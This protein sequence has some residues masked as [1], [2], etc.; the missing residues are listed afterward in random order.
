M[1]T[2][3]EIFHTKL[4]NTFGIKNESEGYD[5]ITFE[6]YKFTENF[7]NAYIKE[8]PVDCYEI[9]ELTDV[10]DIHPSLKFYDSKAS[11]EDE[12]SERIE[13]HGQMLVDNEGFRKDD[14]AFILEPKIKTF[15]DSQNKNEADNTELK[16]N[17]C[18]QHVIKD[19]SEDL[20]LRSVLLKLSPSKEEAEFKTD[21]KHDSV[22]NTKRF[23]L[24]DRKCFLVHD[25]SY[26]QSANAPI[27]NKS[28]SDDDGESSQDD[29]E[30]ESANKDSESKIS[31]R[32]NS[33]VKF[34]HLDLNKVKLKSDKSSLKLQ[35]SRNRSRSESSEEAYLNQP[36]LDDLNSESDDLMDEDE[37]GIQYK[38][39]SP[40]KL[41][42]ASMSFSESSEDDHSCYTKYSNSSYDIQSKYKQS[43]NMDSIKN[44][45]N[46]RIKKKKRNKIAS[47]V[48]CDIK[49][50]NAMDLK[51]C[52]EYSSNKSAN[53]LKSNKKS[54]NGEVKSKNK[55]SKISKYTLSNQLEPKHHKS[56]KTSLIKSAQVTN[57]SIQ[58]S[59]IDLSTDSSNSDTNVQ[60]IQNKN[61]KSIQIEPKPSQPSHPLKCPEC[62]MIFN[63][64]LRLNRHSRTHQIPQFQCKNC[65]RKFKRK[66][67]LK[68]HFCDVKCTSCP[69]ICTCEMDGT[70]DCIIC[71][72][73]NFRYFVDYK[74]HMVIHHNEIVYCKICE[75]N[76]YTLFKH[77]QFGHVVVRS[78]K[79][80]KCTSILKSK[81][82]LDY[83]MEIHAKNFS[84][85]KCNK[86]FSRRYLLNQHV[87]TH[88]NPKHF[89]CEICDKNF[90][91]KFCL[92]KHRKVIHS[93]KRKEEDY[94]NKR[95]EMFGEKS[96]EWIKCNKC[97]ALFKSKQS[98][99]KHLRQ[100]KCH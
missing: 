9:V 28:H 81:E 54:S 6:D 52:F 79:C 86:I 21:P 31:K 10:T 82:Q 80:T 17:N 68:K 20:R 32:N 19:S 18:G 61:K 27:L 47:Q 43:L 72:K 39:I 29:D 38:E 48:S 88:E 8:E 2:T 94:L 36:N 23:S 53:S 40:I 37:D 7:H 4:N 64:T 83:H 76:N 66:S 33:S 87:L 63:D 25:H 35:N 62:P 30:I 69:D 5:T 100:A 75:K 14:K 46:I 11:E 22:I 98:H 67:M 73:I 41:N 99:N 45:E 1:C 92:D 16:N 90:Q 74:Q 84:C 57:N 56:S 24:K 42:D 93:D 65:L 89:H 55:G 50:N 13:N 95:K 78:F 51:K 71:Q 77:K 12:S 96:F 44:A 58:S 59:T 34:E 91:R 97:P 70:R 60:S 49:I 85:S 26:S 3:S 15:S